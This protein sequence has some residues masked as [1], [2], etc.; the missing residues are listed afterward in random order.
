MSC[1]VRRG[2][3]LRDAPTPLPAF[4]GGEVGLVGAELPGR[5]TGELL[6][7]QWPFLSEPLGRPWSWPWRA[8]ESGCVPVL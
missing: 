6:Q 3:A 8:R 7:G 4:K 2:T 5:E 1:S